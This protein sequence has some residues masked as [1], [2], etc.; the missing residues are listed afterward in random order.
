MD[1]NSVTLEADNNISSTIIADVHYV[2]EQ[3]TITDIEKINQ[4]KIKYFKRKREVDLNTN[5]LE[6]VLDEYK[7]DEMDLETAHIYMNT[8]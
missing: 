2:S 1:V 7:L 4:T 3:N 5:N 8:K 6:K